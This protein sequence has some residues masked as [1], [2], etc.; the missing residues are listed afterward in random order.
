MKLQ[1][2]KADL[3]VMHVV[4]RSYIEAL[5]L[6]QSGKRN[7]PIFTQILPSPEILANSVLMAK[8]NRL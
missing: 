5:N 2:Q 4:I 6:I 7:Y 3:T 8:V 1:I